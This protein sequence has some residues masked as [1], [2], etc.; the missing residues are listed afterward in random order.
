MPTIYWLMLMIC[1]LSTTA[2]AEEGQSYGIIYGDLL[3]P[4]DAGIGVGYD[5]SDTMSLEISYFSVGKIPIVGS[6]GSYNISG[7]DIGIVGYLPVTKSFALVGKVGAFSHTA[8]G[9]SL[10]SNYNNTTVSTG[11]GIQYAVSTSLS[12]MLMMESLG[13]IKSS[14]TDMG[15]DYTMMTGGFKYHF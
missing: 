13:R 7:I 12:I 9:T 14:D 6:V 11:M 10:R 5:L 1:M 8:K 15:W 2:N 3:T 4:S